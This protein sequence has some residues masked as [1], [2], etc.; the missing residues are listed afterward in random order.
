MKFNKKKINFN[1][2]KLITLT[3]LNYKNKKEN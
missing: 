3:R 2:M 1:I